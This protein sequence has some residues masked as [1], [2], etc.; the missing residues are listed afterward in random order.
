[1]QGGAAQGCIWQLCP[2]AFLSCMTHSAS[3]EF[4]CLF[5]LECIEMTM[6]SG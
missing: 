1:V 5:L 6:C 3:G 2:F 4:L